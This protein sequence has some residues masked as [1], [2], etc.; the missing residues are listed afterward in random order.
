MKN[1]KT[2][3]RPAGGQTVA[4]RIGP[5]ALARLIAATGVWIDPTPTPT[6]WWLAKRGIR[7]GR[8][9]QGLIKAANAAAGPATVRVQRAL[10]ADRRKAEALLRRVARQ[11]EE[12]AAHDHD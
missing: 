6:P 11:A 4:E 12:R 8:I 5:A 10:A 7:L 3:R 1:R 9:P 2:R